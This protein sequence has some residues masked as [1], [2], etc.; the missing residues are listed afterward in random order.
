MPRGAVLRLIQSRVRAVVWCLVVGC[1]APEPP[2]AAAVP[3][4]AEALQHAHFTALGGADAL[5][6][7]RLVRAR[8]VAPAAEGTI[9]YVL[10][11]PDLQ[12]F[13][14][15]EEDQQW[16][17]GINHGV[18]WA[19]RIG[20]RPILTDGF[21]GWLV[22]D[23]MGQ[24]V[25]FAKDG[26][27][28]A[29]RIGQQPT[30]AVPLKS[31]VG[32]YYHHYDVNTGLCIGASTAPVTDEPLSLIEYASFD[33]RLAPKRITNWRAGVITVDW[34]VDSITWNPT[35]V[36]P[37][38][39]PGWLRAESPPRT[40]LDLLPGTVPLVEGKLDGHAT[41]F[42]LDL[43][44]E[45]TLV[46]EAAIHPSLRKGAWA[47]SEAGVD[48]AGQS[49][50]FYALQLDLELGGQRFPQETVH[51][52]PMASRYGDQ[53]SKVTLGCR[54]LSRFAI[55]NDPLN[56]RWVLH[57]PAEA[58]PP[59]PGA[60]RVWAAL[61]PPCKYVVAMNAIVGGSI[62]IQLD[63]GATRTHL[64]LPEL[65]ALGGTLGTTQNRAATLSGDDVFGQLAAVRLIL[66]SEGEPVVVGSSAVVSQD[67]AFSVLGW[68][69]I[70]TRP[71]LLVPEGLFLAPPVGP[72]DDP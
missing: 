16:L 20:E 55:E 12:R 70:A 69:S 38:Q 10:V 68:D 34:V 53:G 15:S 27:V 54:F 57:P 45:D 21:L 1:R 64:S 3:P 13:A 7:P 29:G 23:P 47:A 30:W 36:V 66:P 18:E 62:P 51:V 58:P 28:T 26:E 19:W 65:T 32:P 39:M 40:T 43:G 67:A 22:I 50:P 25:M 9:T 35:D 60:V 17:L 71:F 31:P 46:P 48:A 4:T 2:L 42:V 52:L 41:T 56:A 59:P 72:K 11:A 44:S 33:G 8:S 63:T 14:S 49:T 5:T 24:R 37:D 61:N 6:T